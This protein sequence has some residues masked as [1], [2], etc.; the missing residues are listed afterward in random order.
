[1]ILDQVRIVGTESVHNLI[2]M[3][4]PGYYRV[5]RRMGPSL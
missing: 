3:K 2:F 4:F 1:M 5:K